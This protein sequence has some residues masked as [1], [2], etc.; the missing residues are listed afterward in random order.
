VYRLNSYRVGALLAVALGAWPVGLAIAAIMH[1][2][3]GASAFAIVMLPFIAGCAYWLY[4]EL[5]SRIRVGDDAVTFYR[6]RTRRV[7][8]DEAA[9]FAAGSWIDR[10]GQRTY[11]DVYLVRRDGE[12]LK[13]GRTFQTRRGERAAEDLNALLDAHRSPRSQ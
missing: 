3:H 4:V 8:L 11:A 7:P 1:P 10:S 13:A 5:R 2:A 6:F 12:D 9:Q